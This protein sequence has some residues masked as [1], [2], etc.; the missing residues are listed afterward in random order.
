MVKKLCIVVVSLVALGLA[1][2]LVLGPTCFRNLVA[3]GRWR[4]KEAANAHVPPEVAFESALRQTEETLPR[5]IANLRMAIKET[6]KQLE[7][8]T[9]LQ[10]EET[11]ALAAVT[12]DLRML[13]TA[14]I[15]GEVTCNLRGTALSKEAAASEAERLLEKRNQFTAQL[16][17]RETIVRGLVET[18]SKLEGTLKTA[19]E[20]L[21][22][23][24]ADASRVQARIELVRAQERIEAIQSNLPGDALTGAASL[25]NR[26]LDELD[27]RLET[28]LIEHEERQKLR[29][30]P[31]SDPHIQTVRKANVAEELRK[32]FGEN[33]DD[34]EVATK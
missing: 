10:Q 27:K 20:A 14:V 19:E 2:T 29:Q 30:G 21:V 12:D 33:A 23:Y 8:Q 15:A 34:G 24:K 3:S 18:R 28:R 32:L 9:R 25:A 22:A 31:T 5:Q 11:S 17:T 4:I 16:E 1:G 26:Q 7:I 13:S 6:E